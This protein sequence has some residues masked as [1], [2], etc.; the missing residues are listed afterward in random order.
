MSCT[1]ERSSFTRTAL[2]SAQSG[3]MGNRSV[4]FHSPSR[5][6]IGADQQKLLFITLMIL[7]MIPMALADRCDDDTRICQ[8]SC[9]GD[10][11]AAGACLAGCWLV[12]VLCKFFTR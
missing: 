8:Q 6:C 12:H 7:S 10:P 9:G 11:R 2:P 1:I 4:D 5:F 3:K